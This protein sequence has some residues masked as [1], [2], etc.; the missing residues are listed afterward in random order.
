[1]K[2]LVTGVCGLIGSHLAD[3]LVKLGH[4]VIGVDNLSY[5]KKKNL[6]NIIDNKNFKLLELD[7]RN[8]DKNEVIKN[9]K[10]IDV[11]FHLAAY[12]KSYKNNANLSVVSSDVMINNVDMTKSIAN[13]VQH[14]GCPLIYT[15]TS[16]VYGNSQNFLESESITIG[17]PNVE[18]YSYA[19]SKF[20]D[21]QF[22]LNL[23]NENKI[24]CTIARIFGCFSERSNVGLTG[25]HVLHFID[26]ASKDKDITIHGDGNQTRS[27]VYVSDIVEGLVKILKKQSTLNGEIINLGTDEEVSVLDAARLIIK[28]CESNSKIKF[29]KGEEVYGEYKEIRRRFANTKK[30]QKL[31]EWNIQTSFS[32]SLKHVVEARLKL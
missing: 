1:M 25:G 6:H 8:I 21:E 4:K 23:V 18:R 10:D 22:F 12:K 2:I 9:E 19:V 15:S 30:A 32:K 13:L 26:L 11:I 14:I 3:E 5:G 17:P 31:L 27:M 24:K 7:V 20:F 16:D 29:I 28:L